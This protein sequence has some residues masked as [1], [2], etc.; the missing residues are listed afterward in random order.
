MFSLTT[1]YAI[2]AIVLLAYHHHDEL[3]GNTTL[4]ETAKIPPS[5]L[6]KVL[7]SLVKSGL[8][9]SRRGVKGGFHLTFDPQTITLLD[10]VNAVD[11]IPRIKGCPLGLDSHQDMLCPVHAHLDCAMA[12]VE[13]ILSSATI[14]ELLHDPSRPPALIETW[15]REKLEEKGTSL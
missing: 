13:E 8:V 7:Q 12:K 6:S 4:A 10:V 9:Q 11:P 1:Q 5:Y 14:A 15:I 2:R 3:V